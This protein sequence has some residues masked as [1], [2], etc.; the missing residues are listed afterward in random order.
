MKKRL[1]CLCAAILAVATVLGAGAWVYFGHGD[2]LFSVEQSLKRERPLSWTPLS[3]TEETKAWTW[4]ALLADDRVHLSCVMMLVN[5][6]HPLPQG[7]EALLEEYNGARMHPDM[8]DP[9]I[10]L[11][12]AVEEKTRVRIYVSSDYRTPEEQQQ[13]IDSSDDGIA[14][15]LG[16]S[17]HEAGLALDVYAPYYAGEAFLKS[18]AGRQVNRICG[19]YGFILRYPKGKEEITGISHEP[20]HLRYVGQPH[21]TLMSESG[22]TLEEYLEAMEI[23]VWYRTGDYLV[24]K[25]RADELNLPLGWSSCEISPDNCG[26][27]II[28][29]KMS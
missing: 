22:L 12:D 17:E 13:I 14:A 20:W 27:Y 16:C 9:Y 10:A 29:L 1:L 11:R 8:V 28:T 21:A 25:C 24:G 23:G 6:D 26:T 15:P 19:N 4:E 3:S 5:E 2:W 18:P 7:Y